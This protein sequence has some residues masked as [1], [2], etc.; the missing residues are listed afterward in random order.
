MN[1][2]SLVNSSRLGISVLFLFCLFFFASLLSRRYTPERTDG[3]NHAVCDALQISRSS[4][5][6]S[7]DSEHAHRR[8]CAFFCSF[9]TTP[10]VICCISPLVM[11]EE[12]QRPLYFFFYLFIPFCLLAAEG[13]F[14]SLNLC[15]RYQLNYM[16]APWR[17]PPTEPS[18]F[19]FF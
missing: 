4:A 8:R 16:R 7:L 2:V 13:N 11:G 12:Q 6:L 18:F 19:F 9:R 5:R 17:R 15:A 1:L 10:V 14:P 3:K